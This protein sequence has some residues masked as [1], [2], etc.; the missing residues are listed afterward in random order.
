MFIFRRIS[1]AFSL[2]QLTFLILAFVLSIVAFKRNLVWHDG[3]SLW[4]DVASNSPKEARP[5]N[6]LGDA[7][8]DVG[9]Y[10][11]ALGELS[12]S[13][14]A[15][16]WYIEPHYNIALTYIK[17]RKYDKAIPELEEVLRINDILKKGHFGATAVPKYEFQSNANLG[18]IYNTMGYYDKAVKYY[19]E[20][21][22][23]NPL[24]TSVRFNLGI[25]FK[26]M[27]MI[28]EARSEFE[29]VLRVNPRDEGVKWQL[30]TLER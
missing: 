22:K 8:L 29:E 28:E 4:S 6:N 1:N 15:D 17:M 5:H 7:L 13:V 26:K 9:R 30:L 21:L 27:G 11:E 16:Q 14:K 23:I 18:N 24:E 25:T 12:I 19:K 2:E 10:E 20:V 3:I